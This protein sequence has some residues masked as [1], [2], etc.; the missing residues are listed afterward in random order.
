M[1]VN[2]ISFAGIGWTKRLRKVKDNYTLSLVKEL[3]VGN[4]L[5]K[6]Q[7]LYYFLVKYQNRNAV[8]IFLDGQGLKIKEDMQIDLK[9]FIVKE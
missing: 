8:I 2:M 9:Q 7:S 6:G 5:R 3:I 4:A 1:G